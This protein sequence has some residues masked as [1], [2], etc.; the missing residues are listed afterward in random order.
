MGTQ[1]RFSASP[2]QPTNK[3]L[4]IFPVRSRD[5]SSTKKW[6]ITNNRIKPRILAQK[7]F[8]ELRLPV[9]WSHRLFGL[10]KAP[11]RAHQAIPLRTPK[12]LGPTLD[13]DSPLLARLRL[14]LCEE[15][16]E[17]CVAQN[18]HIAG[19]LLDVPM[20]SFQDDARCVVWSRLYFGT[21]AC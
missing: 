14:F 19:D 11:R 6:W 7:D 20:L 18:A 13:L 17:R 8:G 15:G 9:K 4:V 3:A 10:V 21:L 5:R 12:G 2:I 16:R 1:I